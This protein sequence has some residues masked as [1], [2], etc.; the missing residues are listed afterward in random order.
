MSGDVAVRLAEGVYGIRATSPVSLYDTQ[1]SEI[2]TY[3]AISV[4]RT[5]TVEL[6]LPIYDVV[7]RLVLP[8]GYYDTDPATLPWTW[9]VGADVVV[10]G[11]ALGKTDWQ[12]YVTI[13]SVPSGRYAVSAALYG[14]DISPT[15][16]LDVAQTGTQVLEVSRMAKVWFKA[17]T[18]MGQGIGLLT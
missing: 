5:T 14:M 1:A 2:S 18:A 11:V 16:P 13:R 8:A 17:T 7:V 9:I 10:D 4:P 12:G 6:F 3:T 15:L